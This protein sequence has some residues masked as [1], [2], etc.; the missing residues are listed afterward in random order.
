M[1]R[2]FIFPTTASDGWRRPVSSST[3]GRLIVTP[4]DWRAEQY[5][6]CL[7]R[8]AAELGAA[9]LSSES[10]PKKSLNK[11]ALCCKYFLCRRSD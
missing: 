10:P 6:S 2:P 5:S 9:S 3:I 7:G 11:P 1:S 8:G 4:T